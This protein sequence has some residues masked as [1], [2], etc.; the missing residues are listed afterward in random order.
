MGHCGGDA[1]DRFDHF[2]ALVE[3]VEQGKPPAFMVASGRAFPGRTRPLCAYPQQSRYK[4]T[5]SI[6]EAANFTCQ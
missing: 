4:G 1:L 3:W 6:E 5:G 2:K